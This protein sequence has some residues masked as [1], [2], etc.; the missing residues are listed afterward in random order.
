MEIKINTVKEDIA[1]D[2]IES[3]YTLIFDDRQILLSFLIDNDIEYIKIFTRF[4]NKYIEDIKL[5]RFNREEA[6]GYIKTDI[7]DGVN[8]KWIRNSGIAFDKGF[9][10]LQRWNVAKHLVT[11]FE[12]N[13]DRC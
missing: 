11:R 7:V 8:A 12:A 6:I 13:Y 1:E 9:T 10:E 2:F 4:T 5:G 3:T